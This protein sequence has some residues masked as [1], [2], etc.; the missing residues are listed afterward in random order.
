MMYSRWIP[1]RGGYAYFDAAAERRGIADDLP[2]P[3]LQ[4]RSPIGF[5][6]TEAGRPLP[7]GA[8]AVGQGKLARGSIVPMDRSMLSGGDVAQ[9]LQSLSW[10]F[11]GIAGLAVG[12]FLRGNR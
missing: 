5:P 12:Y 8:K 3:R 2:V 7:A 4:P 9:K 11:A 6:S 1:D 10:V